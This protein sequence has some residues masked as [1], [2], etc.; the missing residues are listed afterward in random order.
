MSD[1]DVQRGAASAGGKTMG[2]AAYS[3]R[4]PGNYPSPFYYDPGALAGREWTSWIVP[5]IVVANVAVFV[6]IMC[7]NDCSGHRNPYG[8]CVA[9]FL[10]RFSFQPLRENPLLGPSSST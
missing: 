1:A 4:I 5:L 9:G 2:C 6:G 8:S 10:R 7:V 3:Y